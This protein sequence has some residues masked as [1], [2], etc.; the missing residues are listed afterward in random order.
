MPNH[1]IVYSKQAVQYER[2]ISR[3]DYRNHI[4]QTLTQIVSFE[5]KDIVDLG[6]GTGRLSCMLAPYVNSLYAFDRSRPMLDVLESKL[7]EAGF[8]HWR[9]GVADHR[10]LPLADHSADVVLAGWTICY[11]ASSNVPEWRQ[12]LQLALNEMRRVVRRGGT[13]IILETLGTGHET[14]EAPEFLQNYYHL[15]ETTYGFERKAIRTDYLFESAEEAEELTRFFFGDEL[16]ERVK[17]EN[18][19]TLPECTG[20]WWK[21]A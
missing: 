6:A 18:R 4:F 5:G 19:I 21:S 9:T 12:N 7:K 14:P 11:I 1:D 8:S 17:R 13:I 2:L 20:V 16:A 10:E 3:E 15:L